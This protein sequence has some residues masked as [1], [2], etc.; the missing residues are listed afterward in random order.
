MVCLVLH[1]DRM[2]G[3]PSLYTSLP[4]LAMIGLFTP[5]LSGSLGN[6]LWGFMSSYIPIAE[7]AQGCCPIYIVTVSAITK[8]HVTVESPGR[9]G[10]SCAPCTMPF[11]LLVMCLLK[12]MRGAGS[13]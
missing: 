9:P 7:K 3:I 5:G 1:P 8:D 10:W 13:T 11:A 6:S 4:S 2:G 12:Q